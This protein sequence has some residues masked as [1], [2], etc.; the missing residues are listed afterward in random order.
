MFL[1]WFVCVLLR[2]DATAKGHEVDRRRL[3]G[4]YYEFWNGDFYKHGFL[5]KDVRHNNHN[6][7][8]E[9]TILTTSSHHPHVVEV[10][11]CHR[12]SE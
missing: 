5:F 8:Y 1:I 4:D 11:H 7:I 2:S 3:N 12:R 6:S 9:H 10:P